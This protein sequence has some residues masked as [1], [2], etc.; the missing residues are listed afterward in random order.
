MTIPTYH[1]NI[2][3]VAEKDCE[4]ENDEDDKNNKWKIIIHGYFM[5]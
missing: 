4:E 1:K 3:K 5:L 2:C